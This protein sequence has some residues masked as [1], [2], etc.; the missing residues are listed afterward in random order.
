MGGASRAIGGAARTG[1]VNMSPMASPSAVMSSRA[2][3]N[4]GGLRF[5]GRRRNMLS[6]S[7][8]PRFLLR[9]FRD[10]PRRFIRQHEWMSAPRPS[11]SDTG[12]RRFHAC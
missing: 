11:T 12:P 1:L 3:A 5:A 4:P 10:P 8:I 9:Q 2:R 7:T 6:K